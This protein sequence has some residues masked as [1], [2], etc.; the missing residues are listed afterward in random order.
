MIRF[1]QNT[2]NI[3]RFENY[4]PTRFVDNNN[5]LSLYKDL[6]ISE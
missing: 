2:L 3:V 4:L 6:S 5:A 1:Q